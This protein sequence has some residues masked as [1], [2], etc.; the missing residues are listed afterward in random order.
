MRFYRYSS[1]K[2]YYRKIQPWLIWF[3]GAAF[4]FSEYFVRVD[5]SVVVPQLMTAFHVGAFALGSLSG[6]FY[7]SYIAMQLPVGAL[8]DRYG[9]H[10]L[11]ALMAFFCGIACFIFSTAHQLWVAELSRALMGFTAA[12]AFIGAI[13]L[14]TIWFHSRQFGLLVGLIQGIGM[15]GAAFGEGVF[16]FV[17][18]EIGWRHTVAVIAFILLVLSILIGLIVRDKRPTLLSRMIPDTSQIRIWDG[19]MIVFRNRY[20]WCVALYA[21]LVY[22]ST[23]AFA[24]LWGP[25]FLSRAYD[26]NQQCAALAVSII[27]LGLAIGGPVI[28]WVSDYIKRRRLI[29]ITSAL[30]SLILISI[31]LYIPHLPRVG[32]L[33]ILFLYGVSNMGVALVYAVAA[34]INPKP[35]VGIAIA[36]TNMA[37]VVI[38]SILQP[39]IGWLLEY[40][41]QGICTHGYPFYSA[42]DYRNA[43]SMLPLALLL[44]AV[45]ALSIKETYCRN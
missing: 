11:L 23:G 21:G 43:M 20:S 8:V 19:L 1:L 31:V 9:P 34:E 27:F 13:K 38:V 16:T 45:V 29:L 36:F 35:V 41:W 4:F 17:V 12:F 6:Y 44:A 3:L 25:S 24:E 37:S 22:A 28:G 18:K 14:T 7:Y 30:A 39:F 40:H 33:F 2:N 42:L 26:M 32:L 15:L 5:P 10:R